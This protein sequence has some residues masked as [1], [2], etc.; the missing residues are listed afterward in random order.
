[1]GDPLYETKF[2]VRRN[3]EFDPFA[4]VYNRDWGAD[5]H[6]QAFPIVQRL[7]LSR[8]APQARV[9]DACCGTGQFTA[10][11]HDSGFQ[12]HGLDASEEMIRYAR[13]NAPEVEFTI[14]DVRAFHLGISFDAA[15]SV[16]ES[17]NHIPDY[18]GLGLA[19]SCVRAHLHRGAPFLF[20]LNRE[21]A[22]FV[23]WND[24]HAIVEPDYVCAL[25]SR[26]D[27]KSRLATC[28]LTVFK[29][30][31][32]WVRTDFT[33]HQTC[34]E[35]GRVHESLLEA[36]FREVSLYDSCDLGLSGDLAYARTFFFAIA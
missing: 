11:V 33:I 17:F 8:L 21:D 18:E 36:G 13:Q 31:P 9:L 1:M 15:F 23:Y 25:R 22:F 32:D 5:Y 29:Q 24:T 35:I 26:Y 4:A 28:K 7:I 34:H 19:F 20:D 16:F 27:E 14:A 2:V 10:L 12:V 6:A 3:T 30:E